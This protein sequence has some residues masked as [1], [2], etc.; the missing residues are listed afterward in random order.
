MSYQVGGLLPSP[1]DPRDYRLVYGTYDLAAL[2]AEWTPPAESF[3]IHD[4]G[5]INSCV[6]HAIT[7]QYEIKGYPEMSFGWIYGDR[8]YTDHKGEG[9]NTRE[10]LKTVQNDGVPVLHRF[11]HDEEVPEIIRLFESEA[12]TLLPEA[13]DRKIGNYYRLSSASECRRAMFEGKCVVLGLFLLEGMIDM[14]EG[15]D[16]MVKVPP[17][18]DN[19]QMIGGHLVGGFGWDNRGIRFANSWS[20]KWG[21]NGFGYIEDGLFTWSAEHGFPIPLVEAW[22]FELGNKPEKQETGWYQQDGKWRY[23]NTNGTDHTGWLK[24][25]AWFWLDESGNMATGW[26]KIDGC[27]YYFEPQGMMY[28]GWLYDRE[29]DIWYYLTNSGGMAIGWAKIA[30]KWYYFNGSGAMVTGLQSIAGKQYYFFERSQ[31]GHLRGE[32]LLTDGS[33]AIIK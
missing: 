17:E 21:E 6:G 9:L 4:Q 15:T 22:A 1:T 18:T 13:R 24:T 2:P 32:M 3:A 12:D 7:G 23:R 5:Q 30:G 33:G 11:P 20:A 8:R 27:W 28:T 31:G 26:R 29:K 14:E 16:P 10:A 19:F 25:W